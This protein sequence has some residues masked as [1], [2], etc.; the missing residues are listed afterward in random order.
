MVRHPSILRRR[1]WQVIHRGTQ[2]RRPGVI[3]IRNGLSSRGQPSP[4][5]YGTRTWGVPPCLSWVLPPHPCSRLRV[6]GRRFPRPPLPAT[7][8]RPLSRGC[9]CAFCFPRPRR[10]RPE[11]W[12]RG[13][14]T[15]TPD[16][17]QPTTGRGRPWRRRGCRTGRVQTPTAARASRLRVL[18]S[19]SS[20]SAPRPPARLRARR[21]TQAGAFCQ[22]HL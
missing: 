5:R 19:S 6:S 12:A 10:R 16:R 15:Q 1:I 8:P 18:L 2:F 20:V 13:G 7:P 14:A 21:K 9:G 17:G 11:R 22:A 4:G 3:Y